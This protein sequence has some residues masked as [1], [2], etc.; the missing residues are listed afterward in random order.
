MTINA[1]FHCPIV[2]VVE[3]AAAA[4]TTNNDKCKLDF[5]I[6]FIALEIT[7]LNLIIA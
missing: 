7:F 1:R 3:E 6:I 4:A 5:V 2:E